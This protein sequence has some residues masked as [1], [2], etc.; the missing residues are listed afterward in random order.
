MSLATAEL[1]VDPDPQEC[2]IHR[3]LVEPVRSF[4]DDVTN[5]L[6]N[7]ASAGRDNGGPGLP[8]GASPPRVAGS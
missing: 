2:D 3:I 4:L 5:G 7:N 1:P 6:T 8:S